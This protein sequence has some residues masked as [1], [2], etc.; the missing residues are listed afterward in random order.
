MSF[1]YRKA[2]SK[3]W[4]VPRAM[5]RVLTLAALT[6]YPAGAITM[7]VFPDDTPAP[8]LLMG[9]I[10]GLGL[11]LAALACFAVIAPSS[12]QRIV[13]EQA[14]HLDEFE[15]DLRRRANAMAYQIF[16]GLT[17]LGLIYF[18]IAMDGEEGYRFWAPSTFDHWNAIIWGA[19]LYAFVLPTAV[20]AWIAP[21]PVAE[22]E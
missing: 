17:L 8:G 16:A 22:E 15:L 4:N 10:A 13:G 6:A 5:M 14:K 1:Y 20:L 12:L 18:G 9:E 11:I 7:L 19:I 2:G 3:P 21:A